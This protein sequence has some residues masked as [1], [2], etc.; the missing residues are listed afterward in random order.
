MGSATSGAATGAVVTGIVGGVVAAAAIASTGGLAT[1]IAVS[2]WGWLTGAATVTAGWSA[3]GAAAVTVGA[4]GTGALAGG[5]MGAIIGS[6]SCPTHAP[7]YHIQAKIDNVTIQINAAKTPEERAG[8]ESELQR[9]EEDKK[10]I[11]NEWPVPP[12]LDPSQV[13]F[14]IMGNSGVGKSSLMNKLF[15]YKICEVGVNECTMESKAFDFDLNGLKGKMW[16]VPGAGTDKFPAAEYIK[17]M[18]LRWFDGVVILTSG[19]WTEVDTNLF[20]AARDLGILTYI[21]RSKMDQTIV[22]NQDDND[23]APEE[24]MTAVRNSLSKSVGGR[25]TDCIFLI[26][27]RDKKYPDLLKPEWDKFLEKVGEGLQ[28]SRDIK[29]TSTSAD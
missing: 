7:T 14:A 23:V 5:T 10:A 11:E 22:D 13:N 1:P 19:R 29:F 12:G 15:G 26:T 17:R 3:A 24:T 2:F 16:D 4:V 9:L 27:V 25:D 20:C 18:G 21:V 28:K 8:M 6:S